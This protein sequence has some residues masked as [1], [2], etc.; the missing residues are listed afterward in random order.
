MCMDT[1]TLFSIES[2]EV[3][4]SKMKWLPILKKIYDKINL[5][6]A[7]VIYIHIGTYIRFTI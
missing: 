4:V 5:R 7:I 3:N 6:Y 1:I 2:N